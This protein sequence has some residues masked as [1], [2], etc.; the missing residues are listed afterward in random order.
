MKRTLR[1]ARTVFLDEREG[2]RFTLGQRAF[3]AS[4]S[5][6]CDSI[7]SSPPRQRRQHPR[8][9]R[10][11]SRSGRK[12]SHCRTNSFFGHLVGRLPKGPFSFVRHLWC[13]GPTGF[14]SGTQLPLRPRPLFPPSPLF[15]TMASVRIADIFQKSSTTRSLRLHRRRRRSPRRRRPLADAREP[16]RIV[17]RDLEAARFLQFNPPPSATAPSYCPAPSAASASASYSTTA[18]PPTPPIPWTSLPPSPPPAGASG[19]GGLGGPRRSDSGSARPD[20]AGALTLHE[21][22]HTLPTSYDFV[23][24]SAHGTAPYTPPA[25][26]CCTGSPFLPQQGRTCNVVRLMNH[27][28]STVA[29]CQTFNRRKPGTEMEFNK[30]SALGRLTEQQGRLIRRQG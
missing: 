27:N 26:P 1:S 4:V 16:G 28:I 8:G 6:G 20:A 15:R 25:R 5:A 29:T 30:R 7:I 11:G 13:F 9:Q 2:Q 23:S 10:V 21:S 19:S 22:Q 3:H 12:F 17:E 18:S 24:P 14:F